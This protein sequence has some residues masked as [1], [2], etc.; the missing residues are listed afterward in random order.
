M[1]LVVA[2]CEEVGG[3][4]EALF[5]DGCDGLSAVIAARLEVK[6]ARRGAVSGAVGGGGPKFI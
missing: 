1:V 6:A 3:C 2:G 4:D 5:C